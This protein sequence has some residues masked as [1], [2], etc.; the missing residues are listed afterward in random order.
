MKS[1]Y[2]GLGITILA[3][4]GA[5][6]YMRSHQQGFAVAEGDFGAYSYVCVDGTEFKMSPADDLTTITLVPGS[7]ALFEQTTLSAVASDQG[8]RFEGGSIVFTGAGE[9][10]HIV[11]D[12]QTLDC[13]PV[14]RQDMAPFNWGDAGEGAGVEQAAAAAVMQ[15]IV[16]TWQSSDDPFFSREFKAGGEFIDNYEGAVV[17]SGYWGHFLRSVASEE[18]SFPPDDGAVYLRLAFD[19]PTPDV[20]HFRVNK[21]TPEALELTYMERGNTLTFVRI[22]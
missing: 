12:K 1:T 19:E 6:L 3:I 7:T 21:L 14:R 20:L 11:T 8:A 22:R 13:N 16:G 9:G 4:I 17:T 10:V 15:N 18:T 2:V 5:V